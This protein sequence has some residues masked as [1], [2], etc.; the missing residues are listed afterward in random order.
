MI[1]CKLC[2]SIHNH[3]KSLSVHIK[4]VHLMTSKEYINKVD[5]IGKCKLCGNKTKYKKLNIGYLLYCFNKSKFL[6]K[7]SLFQKG[8]SRKKHKTNNE[9]IGDYRSNIS[10]TNIIKI[11]NKYK[12]FFEKYNYDIEK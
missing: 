2:D 4:R 3:Y 8:K 11:E 6:K 9:K 7:L 5:G 10:E 12:Y 1:K